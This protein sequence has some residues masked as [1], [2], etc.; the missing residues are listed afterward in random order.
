MANIKN[1]N[2]LFITASGMRNEPAVTWLT[3]TLLASVR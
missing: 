2:E 1:C 3:N